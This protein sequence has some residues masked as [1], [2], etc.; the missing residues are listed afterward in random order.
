MARGRERP[1]GRRRRGD[2][3]W[4]T[5]IEDLQNPREAR[6]SAARLLGRYADTPSRRDLRG[7]ARLRLARAPQRRPGARGPARASAADARLLEA[8]S[9]PS[10]AVRRRGRAH[11]AGGLDARPGEPGA[12]RGRGPRPRRGRRARSPTTTSAGSASAPRTTCWAT[13]R[14]R[15]HAYEQ[16]ARLDPYADQ[17]RRHVKNLRALLG[18]DD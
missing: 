13:S 14:G 9:D 17:V 5:A 16:K 1:P 11:G 12:A 3:P 10:W 15:S 2:R 6:A 4:S 18:L 7:H 8:L